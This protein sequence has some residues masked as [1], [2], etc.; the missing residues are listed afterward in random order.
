[1]KTCL[2]FLCQ[3]YLKMSE[4]WKKILSKFKI[5]YFV[6]HCLYFSRSTGG[7]SF[8]HAR[9]PIMQYQSVV[10][11]FFTWLDTLVNLDFLPIQELSKITQPNLALDTQQQ[12]RV[13]EW[14]S[15]FWENYWVSLL[16]QFRLEGIYLFE[17]VKTNEQ[18]IVNKCCYHCQIE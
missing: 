9:C 15:L 11:M 8:H 1:M 6:D 10:A 12:K 5:F 7:C 16:K 14:H 4:F 3:K 2:G 13:A 17:T 18:T